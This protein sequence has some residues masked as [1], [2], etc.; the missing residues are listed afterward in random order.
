MPTTATSVS[1]SFEHQ[2]ATPHGGPAFELSTIC[3][4]ERPGWKPP[5][6]KRLA[7]RLRGQ[8]LRS[9]F[10]EVDPDVVILD[11]GVGCRVLPGATDPS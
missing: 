9:W 8:R 10:K 11:D 6:S 1:G 3:K 5:G 7:G 4:H 2:H